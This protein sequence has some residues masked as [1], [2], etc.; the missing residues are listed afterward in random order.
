MYVFL[1]TLL[2]LMWS[3]NK[4]LVF[5][6]PF[7]NFALIYF[8]A[9]TQSCAVSFRAVVHVGK[10]PEAQTITD[11]FVALLATK[12]AGIGP[13]YPIFS[14]VQLSQS[15]SLAFFSLSHILSPHLF[16]RRRRRNENRPFSF[17][18]FFIFPFIFQFIS[19]PPPHTTP[20]FITL[21]SLPL[22]LAFLTSSYIHMTLSY[23]H[24]TLS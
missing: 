10:G 4:Y 24:M 6:K 9:N 3:L 19:S 14:G 17:F 8:P 11:P 7:P 12:L 23:I 13:Q 18:F 16:Y 1:T 2:M 20:N 15:P 21:I 22:S 5:T